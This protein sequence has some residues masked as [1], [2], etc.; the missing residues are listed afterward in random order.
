MM[1]DNHHELCDGAECA[2]WGCLEIP[3]NNPVIAAVIA[4][5]NEEGGWIPGAARERLAE[6]L[7]VPVEQLPTAQEIIRKQARVKYLGIG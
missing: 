1:L 3:E 6:A 4:L 2:T 5:W 7:G